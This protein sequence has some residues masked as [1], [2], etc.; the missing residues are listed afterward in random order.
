M[1]D[2][3]LF[4]ALLLFMLNIIIKFTFISAQ[5]VCMDEPFSVAA[6]Q[7]PLSGIFEYLSH[8]NNPPLFE[9]LLHFIVTYVSVEPPYIRLISLVASSATASMIF[10]LFYRYKGELFPAMC[11][12]LVYSFSSFHIY[13]SHEARVYA[14]FEFFTCISVYF[15]LEVLTGEKLIRYKYVLYL[16][17]SVLM[18]YSHYFGFIVLFL[19]FLFQLIYY[20]RI[21]SRRHIRLFVSYVLFAVSYIY[22]ISTVLTRYDDASKTHWVPPPL[23]EDLYIHILKYMNQPVNAVLAI[24]LLLLGVFIGLRKRLNGVPYQHFFLMWFWIPYLMLFFISFKVPVYLDRYLIFMFPAFYILLI[25]GISFLPVKSI[26]KSALQVAMVLLMIVTCNYNPSANRFWKEVVERVRQERSSGSSPVIICPSWSFENFAY[27]YNLNFFRDYK[28]T[29]SLLKGDS[30]FIADDIMD[31]DTIMISRATKIIF[32]DGA[33]NKSEYIRSY[34]H[35]QFRKCDE[36]GTIP[37]LSIFTD[38]TDG[39]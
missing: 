33:S 25:D 23:T 17:S 3:P 28:Q 21:S 10:L 38:K 16:V 32:V 7:R 30:V 11:A 19:F 5:Q 34:L 22:Q 6:A 15:Y 8:F 24:I 35:A 39:Q 31:I 27:Y 1:K 9:V 29:L 36:W 37:R 14:L 2:K 13:F 20:K 4:W 12:A 26:F 18:I